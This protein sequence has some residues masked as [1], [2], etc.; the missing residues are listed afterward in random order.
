MQFNVFHADH[1]ITAGQQAHVETVIAAL[2]PQGF[3]IHSFQLAE[4]FGS[5]PNRLHGPACGDEAVS[6]DEVVMTER[7]DRGWSDPIC[8]RAER[9]TQQVQVIGIRADADT[10]NLFTVYGGPLAP[11]NPEDPGNPEPEA[12]R[13]FWAEHALGQ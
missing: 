10:I 8:E 4:E 7:G 5:I 3:F 12:A 2:D 13:V 6:R 9:P 11:Q 1:G